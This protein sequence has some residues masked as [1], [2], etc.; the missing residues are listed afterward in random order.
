MIKRFKHNCRKKGCL[1]GFFPPPYCG[2]E[3]LTMKDVLENDEYHR[4]EVVYF[5]ACPA[6]GTPI[7][8]SD[9]ILEMI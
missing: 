2:N 9:I 8:D 3:M 7:E 4:S 5:K 6:C 1:V